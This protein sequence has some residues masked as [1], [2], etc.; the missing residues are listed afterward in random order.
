MLSLCYKH[1]YVVAVVVVVAAV[2]PKDY[3]HVRQ[4]SQTQKQGPLQMLVAVLPRQL[5]VL[6][7]TR[8]QHEWTAGCFEHSDG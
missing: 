1:S 7:G 3:I 4:S 8:F 2:V 6:P 5:S